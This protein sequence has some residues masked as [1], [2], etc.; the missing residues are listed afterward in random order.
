MMF[1]EKLNLAILNYTISATFSTSE[2]EKL[3][4]KRNFTSKSRRNSEKNANEPIED[5]TPE[6]GEYC[7][8]CVRSKDHLKTDTIVIL[9]NSR[10][11]KFNELGGVFLQVENSLLENCSKPLTIQ[12]YFLF[13]INA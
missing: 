12:L 13:L 8:T 2:I 7:L 3:L 5:H 10:D 9:L 11:K 6:I 1:I 4:Q